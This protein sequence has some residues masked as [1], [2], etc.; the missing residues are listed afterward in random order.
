[1]KVILLKDIEGLGKEGE[2]VKAKDGYA[3]NFLIPNK[4]ALEATNKNLKTWKEEMT[5][6]EQKE[7]KE[8]QEAQKLKEKIDGLTVELKSKAGEG[9]K[10]FGSITSMDIKDALKAQ[11]NIDIDKRKIELKNNIKTLGTTSVDVKVYPEIT[12]ELKVNITEE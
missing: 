3:R 11:Y 7:E 1:M 4:F 6:R 5:N 2:L 9:G 8:R 12:G 10:L